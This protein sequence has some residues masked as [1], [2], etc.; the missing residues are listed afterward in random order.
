MA[1]EDEII[2]ENL[3][4][5]NL[6]ASPVAQREVQ[7]AN[8]PTLRQS[9]GEQLAIRDVLGGLQKSQLAKQILATTTT[10]QPSSE[11]FSNRPIPLF[12]GTSGENVF[13]IR[14]AAGGID[15]L[16]S[17]EAKRRNAVALELP[18]FK[19]LSLFGTLD[20][21]RL[22]RLTD[23]ME[24]AGEQV[25]NLRQLATTLAPN[26]GAGGGAGSG[27]LPFLP[28]KG[29]QEAQQE[30]GIASTLNEQVEKDI[31]A[32]QNLLE[33]VSRGEVRGSE[34]SLRFRIQQLRRSQPDVQKALTRLRR[35]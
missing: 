28:P 27:I 22:G 2:L 3:I 32:N 23:I 7:V 25:G 26:I 21:P 20:Q 18:Q 24:R 31:R 19:G 35:A 12:K 33:K 1:R 4:N 11:S 6:G 5:R 13:G 14:T 9:L 8:L 30:F 29:V 16:S 34:E 15:I 10:T 17:D